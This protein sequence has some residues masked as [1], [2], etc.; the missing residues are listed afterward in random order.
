MT[1]KMTNLYR[2]F[3]IVIV[4]I[5]VCAWS[6][7]ADK[8]GSTSASYTQ[9]FVVDIRM[10]GVRTSQVCCTLTALYMNSFC[11]VSSMHDVVYINTKNYTKDGSLQKVQGH[12]AG[13]NADFT[14]STGGPVRHACR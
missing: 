8:N 1:R 14:P 10:P 7:M 11:H 13:V 9:P 3:A 2:N 6:S 5:F 4:T 12:R